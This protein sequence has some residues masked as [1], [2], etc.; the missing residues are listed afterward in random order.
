VVT[1]GLSP[2]Y[3]RKILD[4]QP[5]QGATLGTWFGELA[6]ST[7]G[8]VS[9]QIKIGMVNNETIGDLVRRIRG[10]SV[11]GGRYRGGVM[12]TTTHNATTIVRTAVNEIAN[13]AHLDVYKQNQDITTG[14]EYVATL[15]SRTT[16]ICA[17]LDGTVFSWDDDRALRPPQHPNCRSATVPVIDWGGLGV[18]PPDEGTRASAD[19]G[20]SASTN[21]EAWLRDQPMSVKSEV[22][23]KG[24]AELFDAG[25]ITLR[26]AVRRDG[27][28]VPLETLRG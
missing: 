11:G 27:T 19:G 21:Y 5:F 14:Y 12:A 1:E 10:R 3:F 6:D 28:I 4:A 17:R 13:R 16:L 22:L 18:T 24:R 15:D 26:D 8:K 23:G 2:T 9:K 20:V 25:K 7:T